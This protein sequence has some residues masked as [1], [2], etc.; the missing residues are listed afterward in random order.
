MQ[1]AM[2]AKQ[3]KKLVDTLGTVVESAILTGQQKKSLRSFLQESQ[4]DRED[5][6]EDLSLKSSLRQPQAK[7][8]AYESKSGGIID[9]LEETKD[10][11][12]AELSDARKAEMEASHAFQMVKQ[13]L[14][15]EISTSKEKLAE[16][17]SQKSSN[18]EA[19][20][21]AEG[22]MTETE[23]SKAEDSETLETLKSECQGKAVEWED[24]LKSAKGE[25]GALD[26]AKEILQSGVKALIQVSVRRSSRRSL[27]DSFMSLDSE[28]DD[29][30]DDVRSKLVDKLRKLGRKFNSFSLAQV[31]NRAKSDPFTKIKGLI[32]EMIAKLL[33]EQQA[34]ANQ[35]A[36][37]DEEMG[38]SKKAQE[39]K[40]A[41]L[42]KLSA[43]IDEGESRKV[44]L[45]EEIR[46]LES[47]LAEI[48]RSQAEATQLRTKEH[49]EFL[50][51]QAD[52]QSSED[53]CAQAVEVLKE[54][55]SG[56]ALIQIKSS[57]RRALARAKDDQPEFGSANKDA[58]GSIIEF[59]EYAEEDFA[60]LLA[61]VEGAEDQAQKA[62]DKLSTENKVAKAT[63]TAEAKAKSSEVKSLTKTLTEHG[64]D[65]AGLE[66][67]LSAVNMYIE[68]L[69]PQCE[70]KAMS[71]SEKIAAK[72]AEIEGLKEALSILEGKGMFLQTRH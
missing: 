11:A 9:I 33:A 61:E 52:Y 22:E 30:E 29:D 68:K 26:K 32:E 25:M 7:V 14:E 24:R 16:C 3:M 62:F 43:R 35:K 13:S 28:D 47:E 46:N 45:L 5:D 70:S 19:K 39:I 58:G 12:E 40:T 59:L 67:E 71:A 6:S 18:E 17:Q 23:K 20:G 10:K 2:P 64:E 51:A 42:G 69:K 1:A 31:A 56:G 36:F 44:Q 60:R 38:K 65:K 41:K 53:A 54:Y 48:D 55:Y 63:K 72:K 21:S 66:E 27:H 34:E 8:V 49:E 15:S 57:S 50:K 4:K 37:C